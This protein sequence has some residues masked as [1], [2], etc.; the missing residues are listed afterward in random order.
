[1]GCHE[2]EG[3]NRVG[4]HANHNERLSTLAVGKSPK[5]W[6]CHRSGYGKH[7]KDHPDEKTAGPELPGIH[8]KERD[9]DANAG[10][11]RENRKAKHT[12]DTLFVG[13]HIDDSFIQVR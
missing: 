12:E 5:P 8:W 9:N 13:H 4:D 10:D 7:T 11:R 3:D 2:C 1:M 6:Q